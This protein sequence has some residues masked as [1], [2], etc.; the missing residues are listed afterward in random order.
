M[1]LMMMSKKK[2]KVMMMKKMMIIECMRKTNWKL[3]LEVTVKLPIL[4]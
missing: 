2:K 4:E 3:K 1:K